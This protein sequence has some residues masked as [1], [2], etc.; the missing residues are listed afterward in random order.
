M[1]LGVGGDL[2]GFGV[3]LGLVAQQFGG[4]LVDLGA[5]VFALGIDQRELFFRLGF[6]GAFDLLAQA[7]LAL[8]LDLLGATGGD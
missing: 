2:G 5:A 4:L 3:D 8:G 7:F 6:G 1:G